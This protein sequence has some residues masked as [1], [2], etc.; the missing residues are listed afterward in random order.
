MS[1]W[2]S[3]DSSKLSLHNRPTRPLGTPKSFKGPGK[4]EREA[5]R[6]KESAWFEGP[7]LN[8]A[9]QALLGEELPTTGASRAL[10]QA[11]EQA[12]GSNFW[13]QTGCLKVENHTKVIKKSRFLY[14]L[15]LKSANSTAVEVRKPVTASHRLVTRRRFVG[16]W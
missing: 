2:K 15:Y 5:K 16:L 14:R 9:R 3:Y 10:V 6:P 7:Y 8:R 13:H 11:Y 4:Q 1:G 12:F